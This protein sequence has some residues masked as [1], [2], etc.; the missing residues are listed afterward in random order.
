MTQRAIIDPDIGLRLIPEQVSSYAGQVDRL[1]FALM[2]L[3]GLLVLTLAGLIAVFGFRYR[4]SSKA[5]RGPRVSNKLGQR[6]EIGFA[7]L[8]GA[9]FT[10]LFIWA[11]ILYLDLHADVETDT[12]IN[13]IGKQWMWKAQHP[14][15]TR[16]I[17]TLHIPVDQ[18]IRLRLTSQDVIHSFFLPALRLKRDAV[19]GTY[20][21]IQLT[22]TQ[23]GEYRLF[24]TE[25]CGLDH[26]RMR[27]RLVVLSQP[28]YQAWLS[29][30]GQGPSPESAG[31]DLFQSYGCSGCHQDESSTQAPPLAGVFGRTVPLASGGT[32]VADE[33]YLR[34]SILQPQK[35]V[36]AG[37]EPIMPSFSGQISEGEILQ[38]IAYLKSLQPGDDSSRPSAEGGQPAGGR[39]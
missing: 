32:T 11:G 7:L 25:F 24:C 10:G 34:D 31:E 2:G 17:N 9:S 3:S 27:G 19:P 8:L 4:Q 20:T 18:T 35:H 12:T 5:P 33:A 36:V 6:L 13:V 22:A 1:Y 15:G 39:Q 23:P 29:R 21:Y 37:Y 14:D 28:D 16:E 38:I 30:E 26:S